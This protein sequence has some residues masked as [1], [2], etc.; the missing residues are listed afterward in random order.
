MSNI[1]ITGGSGFIGSHLTEILVN[2]GNNVKV[3]DDLSNGRIENLSKIRDK[4]NFL[5]LD[6][7]KPFHTKIRNEPTPEIIFHL[8]CYPRSLSFSNP[9]RDTEVNIIGMINVLEY[10]RKTD[11]KV[12]FSSN[13]GI[14]DTSKIPINERARDIPKTPYDLNKLTS[15]KYMKLYRETYGLEY[16]NFRFATVYGP[17]QRTSPRWKPVVIEFIEKIDSGIAPTIYWDGEQTRDFIYVKDLV[18][19]LYLSINCKRA[20]GETII[21]GSGIETSINQLFKKVCDQLNVSINP[22]KGSKQLGDIKRMKYDCKKA[23][24]I[25]RWKAKTKLEQGIKEI[26]RCKHE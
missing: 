11:A 6:V 24:R 16:V 10:A 8:A 19:A 1:L 4:I 12:I 14:Y 26:I 13:S 25:L 22:E 5:K 18:D 23:Y 15:E 9:I 20:I 3:I 21:L 17:R 2:K 7:S